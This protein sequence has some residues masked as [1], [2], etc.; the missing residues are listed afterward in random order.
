MQFF[1]II[2]YSIVFNRDDQ[3]VATDGYINVD[4]VGFRVSD[5]IGHSFL[6]YPV[7]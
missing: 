1:K 7:G 3:F 6:E 2:A 5:H 4:C